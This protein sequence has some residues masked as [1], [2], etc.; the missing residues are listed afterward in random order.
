MNELPT[1]KLININNKQM[2]YCQRRCARDCTW[3]TAT[4]PITRKVGGDLPLRRRCIL[5]LSNP[6]WTIKTHLLTCKHPLLGT[7]SCGGSLLVKSIRS[8]P[9]LVRMPSGEMAE[10]ETILNTTTENRNRSEESL[11]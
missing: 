11:F 7:P 8:K 10:S 3:I 1:K 6:F 2:Y 4:R 5:L 9:F